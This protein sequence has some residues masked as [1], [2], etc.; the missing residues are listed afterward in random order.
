MVRAGSSP[1][2]TRGAPTSG[3][4]TSTKSARRFELQRSEHGA[5]EEGF[6][7]WALFDVI[8]D[9][10]FDVNDAIDD[11]LDDVEE[12]VFSEDAAQQGDPPGRLQAPTGLVEFRRAAAPMRDVLDAISRQGASP[13]VVR[14]VDPALPR[15]ARPLAAACSTSSRPQR[16][17]LTGLLE[18][19]LAVISNNLNMVMKKV[20][21]WGAILVSATL[22]AGIYGMNFRQMPELEW[23]FGYPFALGSM[24][25]VMA[26]PVRVFK[27]RKWL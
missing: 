21:S 15:A 11:R 3:P 9:R 8:I 27:R 2:V 14:R 6:L 16:D 22:I 7:L 24:V 18:A 25:L 5:T 20:T 12:E 13:F 1:C 10:Y 4:S 23:S 19:D 17:L 26:M